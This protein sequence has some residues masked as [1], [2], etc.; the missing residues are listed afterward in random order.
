[1]NNL[2]LLLKAFSTWFYYITIYGL[3]SVLIT[4]LIVYGL[5]TYYWVN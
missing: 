5:K 1:M 3:I 4:V 2:I